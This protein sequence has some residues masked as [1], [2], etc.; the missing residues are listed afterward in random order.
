MVDLEDN[1]VIC[2]SA[3][4][5]GLDFAIIDPGLS[6]ANYSFIWRDESEY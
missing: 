6:P 4:G 5:G 1:Y 2:E 3:S